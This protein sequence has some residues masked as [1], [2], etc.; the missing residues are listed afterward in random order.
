MDKRNY[1]LLLYVVLSCCS[2]TRVHC[3]DCSQKTVLS[4]SFANPQLFNCQDYAAGWQMY[5]FYFPY[6]L[7][8]LIQ[9]HYFL[10]YAST[11]KSVMLLCEHLQL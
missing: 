8:Q 2:L 11:P 6:I 4:D 5:F 3:L 9:H 7:A 10:K 1:M